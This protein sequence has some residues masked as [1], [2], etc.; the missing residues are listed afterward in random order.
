MAPFTDWYVPTGQALHEVEPV[1]GWYVPGAQSEQLVEPAVLV[2]VPAGHAT[3]LPELRYVP[4]GH[5][6][7]TPTAIHPHNTTNTPIE[8][9]E[10]DII[11]TD[12]ARQDKT[13]QEEE[14]DEEESW[15]NIKSTIAKKGW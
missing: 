2:Y 9:E 7:S 10:Q 5:W 14:E 12:N 1:R 6:A 4:A 8:I 3:Q 11:F 15:S 13:R